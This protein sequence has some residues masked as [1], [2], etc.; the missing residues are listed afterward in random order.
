MLGHV[1]YSNSVNERPTLVSN[2]IFGC[3]HSVNTV[4]LVNLC[5]TMLNI[6][7]VVNLKNTHRAN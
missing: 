7:E 2:Q 3:C 1:S 4:G 6:A 5:L